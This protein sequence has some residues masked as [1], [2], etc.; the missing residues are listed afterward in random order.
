M[1]TAGI[2]NITADQGATFDRVITWKDSNGNAVNLTGY[3]AK[4]QIRT[5]YDSSTIVLEMSTANGR[6]TLGGVLGTITINVAAANMNFSGGQYVYDLEL[7]SAGGTVTRLVM[8]TF[9]L[10]DEVTK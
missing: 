2:Y 7:T 5:T 4:S 6:I 1:S 3:T 9:T 8:G 10:R